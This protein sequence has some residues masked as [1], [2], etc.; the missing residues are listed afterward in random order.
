MAGI[1]R[2]SRL[3]LFHNVW[4]PAR[5]I[6]C[7]V[8]KS[9]SYPISRTGNNHL[10]IATF[11]NATPRQKTIKPPSD[12]QIKSEWIQLVNPSSTLNPTWPSSKDDR[13]ENTQN[14]LIEPA[15][16]RE[17]LSRL[18]LNKYTL[19]QVNSK[20]NPPI[21]KIISKETLNQKER[22][23]IKHKKE[24]E[25]INRLDNVIKEIQLKWK[26]DVHD[27]N[28]KLKTV[29][30]CFAKGYKVQVVINHPGRHQQIDSSDKDDLLTIVQ[31]QLTGFGGELVKR[32]TEAGKLIMDWHPIKKEK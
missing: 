22:V 12:H 24:Q 32:Q 21:C 13:S 8:S 9:P 4:R 28:H 26:I 1:V 5:Q 10:L 25:K 30:N 15:L 20:T 18:D 11:F 17:V 19:L 29:Q 27:L 2:V 3:D 31:E 23:K 14:I 16:T 7:I 6:G